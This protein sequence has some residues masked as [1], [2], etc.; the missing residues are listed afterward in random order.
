VCSY[1]NSIINNDII[2]LINKKNIV[3]FTFICSLF[4]IFSAI[5][6]NQLGITQIGRII[7]KLSLCIVFYLFF[8]T[9]STRIS[10][11]TEKRTFQETGEKYKPKT[12]W[13][14]KYI[15]IFKLFL[16]I[17]FI[18]ALYFPITY[19]FTVIHE[20]AHAITGLAFGVQIENINIIGPREGETCH[21]MLSSNLST[22]IFLIAGSMGEI[23]FGSILLILIN[24]N[25][26]MKLDIFIPIYCVIGYNISYN[27]LYWL[28]SVFIGK[29]DAAPLLFYNPQISPQLL[30]TI[31][32]LVFLGLVL[33]LWF[34]LNRKMIRRKDLFM[35]NNYPELMGMSLI[36]I[37]KKLFIKSTKK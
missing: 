26:R 29:G 37:A 35:K 6:Y 11:H 9:I 19:L 3:Y 15:F 17:L 30:L 10:L 34:H 33:Y 20:F 27:P 36:Q 28:S 32:V 5:F 4:F 8:N 1:L 12:I 13:K 16:G 18:S 22:S 14:Y 21:S 31:C 23:L 2:I 24:R 7:F 25:K